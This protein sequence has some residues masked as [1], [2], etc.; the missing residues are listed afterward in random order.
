MGTLVDKKDEFVI[1]ITTTSFKNVCAQLENEFNLRPGVDFYL[2]FMLQ[3]QILIEDIQSLKKNILFTSGAPKN[4]NNNYGGG[5]YEVN[6]NGDTWKVKKVY[7]G[8]CYGLIELNSYIYLA[9][10]YIC[11]LCFFYFRIYGK[12]IMVQL[13]YL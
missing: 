4:N 13:Y 3:D 2:S 9:N 12:C 1:L 8:N 11:I 7:S 5:L 6:L 10:I